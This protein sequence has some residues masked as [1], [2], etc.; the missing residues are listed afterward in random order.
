MLLLTSGHKPS[1]LPLCASPSESCAQRGLASAPLRSLL[2]V[3]AA[4]CVLTYNAI[5]LYLYHTSLLCAQK[6]HLLRSK[7]H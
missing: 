6:Q 4:R 1:L 7:S 3:C 5:L 2:P